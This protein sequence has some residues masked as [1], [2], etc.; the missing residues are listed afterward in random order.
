[1]IFSSYSFLLFLILFIIVYQLISNKY[2]IYLIFC[3][4]FL[5]YSFFNIFLSIA[6]FFDL[7]INYLLINKLVNAQFKNRRRIFLFAIIFNL[8]ILFYFKYF[9]FFIENINLIFDSNYEYFSI[10]LPIGISFFTFQLISY[11]VDLYD[12]KSCHNFFAF[13]NYIIFFPQ[14][15]AGPILRS[16]EI[17]N[18]FYNLD[19]INFSNL[20]TGL[21][22]FSYGLFIKVC[23]SDNLGISID[24]IFNNSIFNLSALDT[25][26]VSYLFGFQIYFD[27]SGYCLMAIGA[28]KI[29]NISLPTNFFFPYFSLNIKEFWQRWNITLGTWVRDYIYFPIIKKFNYGYHAAIKNNFHYPYIFSLLISW[30]VMGFWHG[31]SWN[32]VIWGLFHFCY[33]LLYRILLCKIKYE[34]LLWPIHINLIM[35]SWL[36]FRISE[37]DILMTTFDNFINFENY[38]EMNLKSNLYLI[39]F[40]LLSFN[41]IIYLLRDIFF[42]KL[43]VKNNLVILII[44]SIMNYFSFVYLNKLAVP[45]IYFQF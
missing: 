32:F 1:M 24:D 12:K 33:I 5:F 39:C 31:A 38:F 20:L 13:C 23:I 42:N 29:I 19:K 44:F 36:I 4:N 40:L 17:I 34:V 3:T 35:I 14:L 9:N 11:Y 25:L 45:F 2:K 10:L 43:L 28:S 18:K 6:L 21:K 41:F 16:K 22:Y 37:F 27:F 15:I 8:L 7:I 30:I 26:V